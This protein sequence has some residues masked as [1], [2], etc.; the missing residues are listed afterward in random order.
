[1]I[2]K[3]DVSEE[4]GIANALLAARNRGDVNTVCRMR[5]KLEGRLV[6]EDISSLVQIIA[7]G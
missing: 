7:F 2:A 6:P 3:A 1:M 4:D 5:R